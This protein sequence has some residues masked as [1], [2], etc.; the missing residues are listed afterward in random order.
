MSS[1]DTGSSPRRRIAVKQNDR[2][3]FLSV[4]MD[5]TV[6]E[7]KGARQ[8][9]T[10]WKEITLSKQRIYIHSKL[11][12]IRVKYSSFKIFV[13]WKRKRNAILASK[14]QQQGEYSLLVGTGLISSRPIAE[15]ATS[16]A[17][18]RGTWQVKHVDLFLKLCPP[19]WN[20]E[21]NIYILPKYIHLR[22]YLHISFQP[23]LMQFQSWAIILP[24]VP[25]TLSWGF[26][27]Y[28]ITARYWSCNMRTPCTHIQ[29]TVYKYYP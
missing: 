26:L 12:D 4:Q 16:S 25:L 1:V 10:G 21:T 23:T 20:T 24:G 18:G 28:C 14:H 29:K 9:T 22:L 6:K 19:H 15:A 13:F 8:N 27:L 17:S 7:T 11:V 3:H 2:V 5:S